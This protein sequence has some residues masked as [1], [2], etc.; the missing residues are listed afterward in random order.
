MSRSD[1]SICPVEADPEF[2]NRKGI[3][4]PPKMRTATPRNG[5]VLRNP[6]VGL[7][8][9]FT[10]LQIPPQIR[11]SWPVRVA[12]PHHSRSHEHRQAVLKPPQREDADS[13]TPKLLVSSD[14]GGHH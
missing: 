4:P 12:P 6:R 1:V 8:S 7:A 13:Q 3:H 10:S 14:M 11:V 5:R 2:L 9:P